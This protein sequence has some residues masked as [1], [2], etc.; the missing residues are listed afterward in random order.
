[1]NP[2]LLLTAIALVETTPRYEPKVTLIVYG[3]IISGFITNETQYLTHLANAR[4]LEDPQVRSHPSPE[5]PTFI[6]LRDASYYQPGQKPNGGHIGSYTR[7]PIN[8]VIGF[9]FAMS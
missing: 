1:M 2:A 5:G 9:S 7:V 6:H 4:H 8:A 3:L